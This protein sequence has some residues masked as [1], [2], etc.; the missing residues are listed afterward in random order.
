[1]RPLLVPLIAVLALTACTG[2]GTSPPT[3]SE[4]APSGPAATEPPTVEEGEAWIATQPHRQHL[5]LIRPDGTDAAD[6]LADL[7]FEQFH[8]DWSPDGGQLAFEHAPEGPDADVRDVW[9]SDADGSNAE[10]LV[11]EYPAELE[12]LFWANPAWSPDGSAIAM[13][14][15]EGNSSLGPPSRSV[16]AIA[17]LATGEISVVSEYRSADGN[18]HTGPRWS[19][20]GDRLS[21]TLD[22]IEGD[23]YL[24]GTIAVIERRNGGWTEPAEITDVGEFADRADWHPTEELLVFCTYDYSAF[25]ETDEPSNIFTIRPDGSDRTQLTDFGPGEDRATQPSWTSD[26]R[27]LYT[28]VSGETDGIQ[29]PA[30]MDADG[31]GVQIVDAPENLVHSRLRPT[32]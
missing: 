28:H 27:I 7:P 13:V 20:D 26:G 14:G 29:R 30:F 19:K 10:P 25:F 4:P 9:I 23:E 16:L 31:S 8:P 3:E 18:L 6:I 12:G 11:P 22:H 15:Y 17:D 5:V 21:F 32:S 24:G 1:M 2:P